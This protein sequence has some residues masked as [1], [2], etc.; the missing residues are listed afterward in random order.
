MAILG[1]VICSLANQ[2]INVTFSK[3]ATIEILDFIENLYF[4][5]SNIFVRRCKR[6]YQSTQSSKTIDSLKTR[7]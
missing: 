4:L 1:I 6:L 3:K 2:S 7:S 5:N